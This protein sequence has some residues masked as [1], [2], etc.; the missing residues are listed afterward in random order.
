[1]KDAAGD[2]WTGISVRYAVNS[3]VDGQLEKR[4]T[5]GLFINL[6]PGVTGLFPSSNI[7]NAASPSNYDALKPG[8]SV[9]VMIQEIDEENRRMT[10]ASPEQKD[11]GSW[12]QFAASKS[13]GGFG[14]MGDLLQE[15]LDRD[16]K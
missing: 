2:P 13:K 4:E 15:A 16:K 6:E 5:F 9:K 11:S 10:L 8:D 3:V 14:S 7:R 12:K 1:M